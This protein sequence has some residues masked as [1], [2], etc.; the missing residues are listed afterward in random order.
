MRRHSKMIFSIDDV[1]GIKEA[2]VMKLGVVVKLMMWVLLGFFT[3]GLV[4]GSFYTID[5]GERGVVLTY[6]KFEKIAGAGLHFKIPMVNTVVK[7][8]VRTTT[9]TLENVLAYSSDQQPADITVSIT[10]AV[11]ESG[12]DKLYEQFKN[13]DKAYQLAVVPL[14]KQELKTVFGQY[15]ALR[16][17][18]QREKLNMDV[19]AAVAKILQ[20][21]PYLILRGVQ[22]E[23]IDY[24]KAYEQTIEDR[25]KAEVEVERYKQNLE[26]EKVEAQI[27]I[28]RAEAEAAAKVKAAEGEAKA[29]TLRAQAEAQAIREKSEALKAN[30]NIIS[31]MQA[32]KWNGQLP[33]TMLP[34]GAVPM[35]TMPAAQ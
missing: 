30:P 24:S 21:Y 9:G 12:V 25:M 19:E 22:I 7:I 6:G 29:I 35:L 26:R 34:N 8:P 31:L 5:E 3:F 16:A 15:T 33:N 20:P 2:A 11:S 14:V 27:A 1:Q 4:M 18:Q 28:T 32:E 23:N 17:V 13:L 10:L